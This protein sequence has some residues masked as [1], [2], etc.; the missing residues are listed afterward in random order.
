MAVPTLGLG[1]GHRKQNLEMKLLRS[2]AGYIRKDQINA[3]ILKS[4]PQRKYHM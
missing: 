2:V 1:R 4:S 3:E